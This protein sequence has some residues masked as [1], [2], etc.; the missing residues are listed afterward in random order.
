[1]SRSWMTRVSPILGEAGCR[2]GDNAGVAPAYVRGNGA[3][4]S[5]V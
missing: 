2:V 5:G 3:A 4:R 1:M